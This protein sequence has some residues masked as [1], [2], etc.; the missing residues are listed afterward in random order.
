MNVYYSS[1]GALNPRK[2]LLRGVKQCYALD[3]YDILPLASLTF[4]TVRIGMLLTTENS[5]KLHAKGQIFP[6]DPLELALPYE[7]FD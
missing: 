3:K 1:A 2:T 4:H 7:R 5:G 6:A